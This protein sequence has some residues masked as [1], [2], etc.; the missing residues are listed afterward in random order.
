LSRVT[1]ALGLA[2]LVVEV[3]L[4]VALIMT[5]DRDSNKGV[6]LGFAVTAGVAFVVSGLI[7]IS[8]RPENRAGIFMAAVG[9]TWFLAAL[10]ESNNPWVFSIGIVIG[11]LAFV[12]F[13]A[14]LLAY[15]TGRFGSRFESVFPLL[16]G[17]TIVGLDL[18]VILVDR[19]PVPSCASCPQNELLAVDAPR[20][21]DVLEATTTAA[22][23]AL[24]LFAVALL[25]RRWR[26][27]APV[28]RRT[29]WP[30]LVAG[31]AALTAPVIDGIVST[32]VS[33]TAA[34][35]IAPLFFVCFAASRPGSRCSCS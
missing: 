1:V 24:A 4:A 5:S 2:L 19:S 11:G 35:A 7:A 21:A 16:V 3:A 34:D 20:L 23:I 31:G 14:L 32:F 26:R 18:A 9:Y 27:A 29:L 13:A 15:P 12:P 28:L 22:G 30:V 25:V 10:A 17:A 6:S 33:T 8:R